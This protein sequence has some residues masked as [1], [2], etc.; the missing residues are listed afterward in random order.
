MKDNIIYIE[1]KITVDRII[2]LSEKKF[3]IIMEKDPININD[4]INIATN[5]NSNN[6]QQ[7]YDIFDKIISSTNKNV[8]FDHEKYNNL[9]TFEEK[10]DFLGN[11]IFYNILYYYN[12]YYNDYYNTFNLISKITGMLLSIND[13][14][15]LIKILE[16]KS[17]LNI[18]LIES[19]YL[20]NE[21]NYDIFIKKM[22]FNLKE[23]NKLK[24]I[25]EKEIFLLEN[26]YNI[27][28][29]II[30]VNKKYTS[31]YI[32]KIIANKLLEIL[33]EKEII[34][35][36]DNPKVLCSHI[37][38]I[39]NSL[40]YDIKYYRIYIYSLEN[41]NII[42]D[43][44]VL[45]PVNDIALL[46]NDK[47][48]VI[49]NKRQI[50]ICHLN[51]NNKFELN[52]YI[53]DPLFYHLSKIIPYNNTSFFV[54]NFYDNNHLFFYNKK[55]ENFELEFFILSKE[56]IETA[57]IL[58]VNENT[59]ILLL[60]CYN[61]DGYLFFFDYNIDK[62]K[63]YIY[64]EEK[65]INL[66]LLKKDKNF[67]YIILNILGGHLY[68]FENKVIALN[69]S[70]LYIIDINIKNVISHFIFPD[71]EKIFFLKDN[72]YCKKNGTILHLDVKKGRINNKSENGIKYKNELYISDIIFFEGDKYVVL[73]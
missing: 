3:A 63:E 25:K 45:Y 50:L 49:L 5:N 1:R 67:Q 31:Y 14:K 72:F 43:I 73:Y 51:N 23:L 40:Y 27:I 24:T 44:I 35:I 17:F 7:I 55:N 58:I 13:E 68:K 22:N 36:N 39:L 64:K 29:N 69:N 41:L 71:I 48:L 20:L 10:K 37:F 16:K 52:Y 12:I 11:D 19:L 46:N 2:K 61:K 4:E 65:S 38:N 8:L 57:N 34:K 9:H 6:N 28:Q 42:H 60:S 26:L 30:L 33:D 47:E 53:Y 66:D 56:Y 32:L 18:Y 21:D 62:L 70:E 15:E 54:T 59:I